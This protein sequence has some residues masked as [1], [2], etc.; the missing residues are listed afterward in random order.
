ML[1]RSLAGLDRTGLR[2]TLGTFFLALAGSSSGPRST[3]SSSSP[4][5]LARASTRVSR[6]S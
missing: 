5:R 6:S 4:K 3:S 1:R 2:L